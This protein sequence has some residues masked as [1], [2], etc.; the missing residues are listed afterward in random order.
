[1][2]AREKFGQILLSANPQ[3]REVA[4]I[5]DVAIQL[6]GAFHQPAEIRIQFGGAPCDVDFRDVRFCES[7]HADLR[8]G[9]IHDFTP[10]GTRITM[11][12]MASLVAELANVDLEDLDFVC[13]ELSAAVSRQLVLKFGYGRSL[14]QNSELL[15]DVCERGATPRKSSFEGRGH[16]ICTFS[17]IL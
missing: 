11:A 3:H 12:G 15:A 1:A 2:L 14:A 4:A 8:R 9:P 13:A 6:A 17:T 5:H 10:I 16:Y 7:L